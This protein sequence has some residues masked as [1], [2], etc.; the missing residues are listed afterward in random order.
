MVVIILKKICFILI[1]GLRYQNNANDNKHS[2]NY[3]NNK[4]IINV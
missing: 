4:N 2:R 1:V 3:P